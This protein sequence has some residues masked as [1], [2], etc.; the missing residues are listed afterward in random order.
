MPITASRLLGEAPV[1]CPV[2]RGRGAFFLLR[3]GIITLLHKRGD[4][5]ER[6]NWRP[7]TLLW[8]DYKIAAKSIANRFL[9]VIALVTSPD[10]SCGVPGRNIIENLRLLHD[11]VEH[12]NAH[13]IGAVILSLDQEKAF[14]RVEWSFLQL[15]LERTGFGPSF[16]QWATLFYTVICSPVLVNGFA[17]SFLIATSFLRQLSKIIYPAAS[18][19]EALQTSKL[20]SLECRREK[21]CRKFINSTRKAACKN[22]PLYNMIKPSSYP[23]EMM[24]PYGN[25]PISWGMRQGCPLSPL[26]YVLVAETV[27]SAIRTHPRI[28]G[29]TLPTSVE[30]RVCQ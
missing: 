26:L 21:S 25:F 4:R 22:N 1:P 10:Q 11:V 3:A 17:T 24:I 8:V 20:K 7:I 12:A 15:V 19:C 27:A 2:R 23:N 18:Y 5:L 13:N 29:Y 16:R 6:K 30:Q 28:T 14:E 9:G